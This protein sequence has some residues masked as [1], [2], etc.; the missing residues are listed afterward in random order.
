MPRPRYRVRLVVERADGRRWRSH[1]AVTLATS[2]NRGNAEQAFTDAGLELGGKLP[3]W[4]PFERAE[5]PPGTPR[6]PGEVCWLNSRFQVHITPRRSQELGPHWHVSWKNVDRTARHDWREVQR[7]KT[8]L[9]GHDC[10][11]V[12]VYPA[13]DRLHDTCNQFHLWALPPGARFPFGFLE[14]RLAEVPYGE[15]GSQ[16]AWDEDAR[17]ADIMT[18]EQMDQLS[19]TVRV[20]GTALDLEDHEAPTTKP[21]PTEES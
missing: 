15:V 12:E 20:L 10:E 14:R 18:R 4:S 21:E 3:P 6:E 7:M 2:D 9:L 11:A 13:E 1:L 17:P 16:R 5:V 19:H 8:E